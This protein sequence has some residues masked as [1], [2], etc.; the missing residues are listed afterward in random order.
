MGSHLNVV[1]W[2]VAD[3]VVDGGCD[4]VSGTGTRVSAMDYTVVESDG[5]LSVNSWDKGGIDLEK[6]KTINFKPACGVDNRPCQQDWTCL[7]CQFWG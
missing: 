1:P 4:D 6:N 2:I 3:V 5:G 7:R